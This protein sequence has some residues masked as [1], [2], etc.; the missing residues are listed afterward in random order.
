[1]SSGPFQFFHATMNPDAYHGSG[2]K[3]PF[4]EG[5]YFKMISRELDKAFTVIPGIYHA[6]EPGKSH[7]FV[8]V[9]DG[10]TGESSYQTYPTSEFWSADG[11][12]EIRLGP[13]RFNAFGLSLDIPGSDGAHGEVRNTGITPWP[14]TI[15][16]PGI[17][18][19]YAWV[20]GMECYHGVVSLDHRLEGE[21]QIAGQPV[22]F[23]GG[24]GYIEKDW[25][26]SF[27]EA[28]IW[29]QTNSFAR[30]GISLTA[31]IAIIPWLRRAFNGFIV[32]LW[33]DGRLYRFATY[34]GAKVDR[35]AI[36]DDRIDWVISDRKYQLEM[37]ARRVEGGILRA[38]SIIEMDRRIAETLNSSVEVRLFHRHG[39][40]LRPL[41]ED[42]GRS[43]GLEAVGEMR[44]LA[45]Q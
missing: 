18:G 7:A 23:T 29:M 20:P 21:L 27:P 36:G 4:F 22:D 17:M 11:V 10:R 28:W 15:R 40:H 41:F 38:P 1:M 33:M 42:T 3:P 31:S 14:V 16:S 32:G 39:G 26:R 8:Q 5:W 34:T 35:L 12:F 44:R 9:M 43:A 37:V 30:P 45:V 2:Q 13:N 19:S 24:R 6:R 25:G